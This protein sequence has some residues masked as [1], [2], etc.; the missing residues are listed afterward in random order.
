MLMTVG[1]ES[2]HFGYWR[3]KILFRPLTWNEELSE[4]S[5]E[6]HF[7]S[8]SGF[9]HLST[10]SFFIATLC[11]LFIFSKCQLRCHVGVLW[12]YTI[13]E[14]LRNTEMYFHSWV[15]RHIFPFSST[16]LHFGE[17]LCWSVVELILCVK[18]SSQ[19]LSLLSRWKIF[20][21]FLKL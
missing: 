19:C 3:R 15:L 10:F 21:E 20:H 5:R 2:W 7:I 14:Y 16:S 13:E 18:E 11:L 4:W 12:L 6:W 9:D 8:H 17:I 1:T